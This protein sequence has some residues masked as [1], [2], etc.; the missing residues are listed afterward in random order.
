MALNL[1]QLSLRTKHA[2]LYE[3]RARLARESRL[4]PA[5]RLWYRAWWGARPIPAGI[6]RALHR[7]RW[8]GRS[9]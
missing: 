4:G 6:E 2:A 7:A 8:R 5:G 9:T 1:N 3:D